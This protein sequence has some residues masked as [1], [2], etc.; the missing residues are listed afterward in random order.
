MTAPELHPGDVHIWHFSTDQPSHALERN[1]TLISDEERQRAAFFRVEHSRRWFINRRAGVRERLAPYVGRSPREIVF[2]TNAFGKPMLV[3]PHSP[4]EF[5]VSHSSGTALLAVTLG[6]GIGID[7]ERHRVDINCLELANRFFTRDEASL[8][9]R[10]D[11][12]RMRQLFFTLWCCKEAWVKARGVGLSFPLDR[13]A[14]DA[15]PG[16]PSRLLPDHAQAS[17]LNRWSLLEPRVAGDYSAAAVVDGPVAVV[18]RF[19]V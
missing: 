16:E 10:L 3:E 8:L 13:C 2:A 14:V 7:V 17:E 11:D 19:A 5:S 4:I 12:R 1:R 6:R 9:R 15:W 18:Q